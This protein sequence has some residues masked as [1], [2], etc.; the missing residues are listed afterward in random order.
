MS[1][2][3]STATFHVTARA[4]FE[5]YYEGEAVSV[6]ATNEVGRFDIL[7]G[8]VDL[9]SMLIAEDVVIATPDSEL[10]IPT[11]NGIATVHGGMVN[12]FLNL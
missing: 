7:P 11:A 9:F 8:H 5:I 2:Q 10:T 3:N 1:K 12:L 4:P 6:S